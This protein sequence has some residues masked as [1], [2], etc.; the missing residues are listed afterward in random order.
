MDEELARTMRRLL[1]AGEEPTAEELAD[2][3]W[4]ARLAGQAEPPGAG[5]AA[6]AGPA[7]A[8]PAEPAADRDAGGPGGAEVPLHPVSTVRPAIPD[9]TPAP[10]SR[11]R[12]R[13]ADRPA[14]VVRV[15]GD[16]ALDEPLALSRALRPLKRYVRGRGK[17]L[18]DEE[19]TA[20]ASGETSLLIPAW[21][22]RTERL[23]AADLVIDT[24]P[25][26]VMW[27]RLATELRT[28]LEDH[29]AFRVV[30]TWSLDTGDTEPRLSVFHRAPATGT[31]RTLS[32][33]HLLDPTGR[34]LLLVLT[35]GVGPLWRGGA[36]T[37]ALGKLSRTG[38]VAILQ[39]LPQALWHRAA[40]VPEPALA[41]AAT[42]G[43]RGPLIRP[44][45]QGRRAAERKGPGGWIPVL[46]LDADW[47]APWARLV[48]GSTT[49]WI[50]MAALEVAV[51]RARRGAARAAPA[52]PPAPP[53]DSPS[54]GPQDGATVV[55][56]FRGEA[57]PGAFELAGYLAAVPLVLPVMR[58][59]QRVMMPATSTALLAEVFLSGLVVPSGDGPAPGG[60]PELTLYDFRPGV[61]EAL[62]DTL[63]RRESLR[64]LD[65]VGR[66]SGKV[67]ARLGGT[68]NF[69]AL[70]PVAAS[71]GPWRLP[72]GSQPFARV[73]ATVLAG[74]G[75]EYAAAAE[76]LAARQR[77]AAEPA[78]SAV[79]G[80]PA[81]STPV[82]EPGP[83]APAAT[84]HRPAVPFT[85]PRQPV[86]DPAEVLTPLIGEAT[87]R[88][89]GPEEG[90]PFH[91][92]GFFVAP[93]WVL[94][95]AH[96]ALAGQRRS[97]GSPR[98]VS[99]GY[100]DRLLDGVVE[101]AEPDSQSPE[102]VWSA[103][104]L[105]LVRL[106]DH[107]EHPCAWVSERT[108]RI[109]TSSRVTVSGWAPMDGEARRY[110]S[111]LT[112]RGEVQ[113]GSAAEFE[114]DHQDE[115]P[116]GLSGGPVVDQAR[117]EVI[118]VFRSRE[119]PHYR[120]RA[121][122]IQQLRRLPHA[123]D[124][125]ADLYHRVMA[126]HD[127][128]H[129][130]RHAFLRDHE[131][132]WTDA[133][134]EI[135]ATAGRALTPGQR[136]SLLGLLA[137]LPPPA[138]GRVLQEIVTSVRGGPAQGL[139]HPPRT[140]RDGLGLL[141][142]L[143]RDTT[144]LEAVLRYAVQA[145]TADLAHPAD[146]ATERLVW[147]WAQD[148]AAQSGLT[149][150][151][152]NSLAVERRNRHR[153]RRTVTAA[154]TP[155]ART[156]P[157]VLLELRPLDWDSGRVD[158][159][160]RIVPVDGEMGQVAE[161]PGGGTALADLATRLAGPLAEAFRRCDEPGHAA[162]LQVAVPG[163]LA[164]LA[165]D[166]WRLGPGDRSL[167]A[168]RPVVVRP[169]DAEVPDED[170]AAVD[171]R[172]HRR[173]SAQQLRAITPVVLDSEVDGGEMPTMGELLALSDE[174]VPILC[175]SPAA[176]PQRLRDLAAAGFPVALWCRESLGPAEA[177]AYLRGV[178][179][180]VRSAGTAAELPTALAALR[181]AAADGA[182]DTYW[183]AGLV[184]M[185]DDPTCP[186]PGDGPLRG[187]DAP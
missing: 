96:V 39:V 126:A 27:R 103:P 134:A 24:G 58:L 73:A 77:E 20:R 130:D 13:A 64:V 59:V 97:A 94:T 123:D 76:L 80:A 12:R 141:Y 111:R 137:Q 84:S 181:S 127:L 140:W 69:R 23:F 139:P 16:S 8:G 186:L 43:P 72:E 149:R 142:D 91:G 124:P 115:L 171:A 79:P 169:R 167:G 161:G 175:H 10:P 75:G 162:T 143:R 184:L 160:V 52:P 29:G 150:A 104:D 14:T 185:Y 6:S 44:R 38:P 41:R 136:T 187:S 89:H 15:A 113:V 164:D 46:Q 55:E 176:A 9:R 50:P 163:S 31:P 147:Q 179:R 119:F 129:A 159:S 5:K 67:A 17:P 19:A 165:A 170:A 174:A 168:E 54:Q 183:T 133:H 100:G 37:A 47:V 87:V 34:S 56:R 106:L 116:N 154:R 105:A 78:E 172:R 53:P 93:R 180:M 155:G 33:D 85:G 102:G 1:T 66:L 109:Y 25:S 51:P 30:R 125:Q 82:P 110:S 144:E 112:V 117:G 2:T 118:G 57:S 158:W 28:L 182:P 145:A 60:D 156:R 120:G 68:C 62:L 152:R 122:G 48:A 26:M 49:G 35:D 92:S 178:Q 74:L 128:Y 98:R 101:W 153:G 157:E 88:V 107:V 90:H 22:P 3:L 148:T 135:G 177:G 32:P 65:V 42:R 83:V 21:R 138:G 86:Y 131:P 121:V 63:T 40:I 132:T 173:W 81:E 71:T 151:F 11:P 108:A 70:L 4:V 61:R 45:A 18:L 7:A 99:I 36:L 95:C 166:T 146:E 114:L